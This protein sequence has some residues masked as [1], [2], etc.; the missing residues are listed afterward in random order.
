[1]TRL[2]T[3]RWNQ[4]TVTEAKAGRGMWKH[5]FAPTPGHGVVHIL[6]LGSVGGDGVAT[7]A[8][9]MVRKCTSGF[10]EAFVHMD[11]YHDD[12][13]DTAWWNMIDNSRFGLI[14]EHGLLIPIAW[15][16]FKTLKEMKRVVAQTCGVLY[17]PPSRP[18]TF[19]SFE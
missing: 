19:L 17:T 3:T 7:T 8:R 12:E 13:D 1:M 15:T 16:P 18:M 14:D 6:V 10:W 9:V 5:T 11:R 2:N 4:Y